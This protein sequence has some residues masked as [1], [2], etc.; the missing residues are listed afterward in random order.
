MS[1]LSPIDKGESH[2]EDLHT[3]RKE[4]RERRRRGKEKKVCAKRFVQRKNKTPPG[5]DGNTG[6]FFTSF[7]FLSFHSLCPSLTITL[8]LT[9]LSFESEKAT[10]SNRTVFRVHVTSAFPVEVMYLRREGAGRERFG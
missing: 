7:P 10:P 1:R 8:T 6:S 3:E 5:Q 2:G 9:G 4:G